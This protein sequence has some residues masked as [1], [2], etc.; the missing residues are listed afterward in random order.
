MKLRNR[1]LLL[2]SFLISAAALVVSGCA[3]SAPERD[4]RSDMRLFVSGIASRARVTDP[5]FLVIPQNGQELF[6]LDGLPGGLPAESYLAV[7]DGTGREDLYYGWNDDGEPTP[8]AE[9]EWLEPFLD[10]GEERSVEVLVVDYVDDEAKADDSISRSDAK[11][12]VSFPAPSRG[13]ELVP[14]YPNPPHGVSTS[15]ITALDQVVNY[16]YLIDPGAFSTKEEY[17][18]ALRLTN[19]DLLIIDAYWDGNQRLSAADITSLKTK[20]NGGTRLAVA[21]LSIGEAE[22]YRPYWEDEWNESPPSW[23]DRENPDWPGNY[24]VKYWEPDWQEL[25]YG[26]DE[27]ALGY[28]LDLGFDGVYLDIID[29]FE[30]FE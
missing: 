19:Y 6:T 5:D 25:I 23:L 10:L 4:F 9:I 7:L 2:I 26:S 21:Y 27:S 28:I 12:Y 14:E 13:L 24:K 22:D 16:L 15:D 3:M 18:D 1:V 8:E 30:Y 17:L 29:A 20:N 11:N